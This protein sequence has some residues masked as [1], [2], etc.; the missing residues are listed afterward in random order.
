MP[1]PEFVAELTELGHEV[2]DLGTDRVAIPYEV[3]CGRLAGTKIKLGFAV[4]GDF[5]LTPPSGPHVSPR[6]LPMNPS[7]GA[8]PNCGVHESP[9]G[10]EWQYWSRPLS[11]WAQTKR[12]AQD[13]LR[14]IHHLFDTL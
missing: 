14:H 13:V 12:K 4:P 10:S 8:H 9:F 7:G 11:H 5:P 6:L 3:P 1:K 2:E